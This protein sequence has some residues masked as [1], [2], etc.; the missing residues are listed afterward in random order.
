MVHDRRHHDLR[1][2]DLGRRT[3]FPV[4]AHAHALKNVNKGGAGSATH[5]AG[6]HSLQLSADRVT[7]RWPRVATALHPEVPQRPDDNH[8]R[9]PGQHGKT[10][11]PQ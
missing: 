3:P 5:A 10:R 1:R 9:H 7:L 11:D 6:P 8:R 4:P 2:I